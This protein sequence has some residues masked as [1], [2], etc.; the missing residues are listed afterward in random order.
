MHKG[1]KMSKA[2]KLQISKTMSGRKLSEK[3]KENISIAK[4][5][6]RLFHLE[7]TKRKISLKLKGRKKP[8]QTE[9]HK[10]KLKENHKGFLGKR[11]SKEFIDAMSGKNNVI[12][13]GDNVGYGSLHF[14]IR[15]YKGRPKKCS[16]CGIIGKKIGR[17]WSIDWANIDHKYRRNL[18][19]YIALCQKCH[20]VYDLK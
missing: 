2:I 9:E 3:H 18:D 17:R 20:K 7:E 1:Q 12:W 6:K 19:D 4:R 5:G 13:K 14:W 15:R 11:H 16:N 8:P 10:R